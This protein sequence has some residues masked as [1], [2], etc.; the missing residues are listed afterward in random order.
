MIFL[1][2]PW[3]EILVSWQ[4]VFVFFLGHVRE[5]WLLSITRQEQGSSQEFTESTTHLSSVMLQELNQLGFW[6]NINKNLIWLNSSFSLEQKECERKRDSRASCPKWEKNGSLDIMA[7]SPKR[8]YSSLSKV[9][10]SFFTWE[11]IKRIFWY[12]AFLY[13][14]CES[15]LV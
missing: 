2:T 14:T 9:F 3:H 6:F 10:R 7:S 12:H 4:W 15:I 5:R 8:V 1:K 11:R 13:S